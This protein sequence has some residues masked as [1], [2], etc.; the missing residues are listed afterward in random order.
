MPNR[1]VVLFS[2]LRE[3]A[4][5]AQWPLW[6]L[7]QLFN[8]SGVKDLALL[9]FTDD[10]AFEASVQNGVKSVV[11]FPEVKQFSHPLTHSFLQ[12]WHRPGETYF[13]YGGHG[14]GDYLEV[15]KNELALQVHQLSR[16]MGKNHYEGILFDAC[17]MANIDAVYYLRK[18]TNYIG[19]CQGY[20]WEENERLE[21]HV[22]NTHSAEVLSSAPPGQAFEALMDIQKN[23]TTN[24][25]ERADLAVLDTTFAQPLYQLV[26]DACVPQIYSTCRFD[27]PSQVEQQK[28]LVSLDKL[29]RSGGGGEQGR[30]DLPRGGS[31][32]VRGGRRWAKSFLNVHRAIQFEY[33]LYPSELLDKHIIDLYPLLQ[34]AAKKTASTAGV[35]LFHKVVRSHVPCGN[36]TLYNTAL[37]GLSVSAMEFS[38]M[39]RPLHRTHYL[40]PE[41]GTKATKKKAK[42]S[43]LELPRETDN[44]EGSASEA[45][46]RHFELYAPHFAIRTIP[47]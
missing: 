14:V 15:A 10:G 33:S 12:R 43:Q 44:W 38:S 40:I 32:L 13:V 34:E 21:N 37:H 5:T 18:N 26:Q 41:W 7:Q 36:S 31:R 1:L 35:D 22:L 4:S 45:A 30:I 2:S 11:H 46:E 27:A 47:M 28:A 16:L 9:S 39:S 8:A 6:K 3:A 24:N 23:F 42:L 17:F 19:A 25:P 20:M 29:R